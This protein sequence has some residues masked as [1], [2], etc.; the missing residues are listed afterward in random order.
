MGTKSAARHWGARKER[1]R[2]EATAGNLEHGARSIR[3]ATGCR[4]EEVAVGVRDQ[5][6]RWLCAIGAIGLGAEAV[7]NGKGASVAA[8]GLGDL[9]DRAFFI[10][11]AECCRAEELAIGVGIKPATGCVP[12]APLKLTRVVGVLA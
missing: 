11:S 7:Q 3:P 2:D 1:R 4:T 12:S 10:H 5:R 6:G 9:E 8:G